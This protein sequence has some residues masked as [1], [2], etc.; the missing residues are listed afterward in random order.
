[1]LSVLEACGRCPVHQQIPEADRD[2]NSNPHKVRPRNLWGRTS[3]T[4]MTIV[5]RSHA[6]DIS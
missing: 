5:G 3:C 2:V 1:M 6:K 4:R